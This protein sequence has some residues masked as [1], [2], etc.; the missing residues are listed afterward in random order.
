MAIDSLEKLVASFST[1]QQTFPVKYGAANYAVT[2]YW[3]SSWITPGSHVGG[4]PTA[5]AGQVCD[6]TTVGR[7]NVDDAGSGNTL[8]LSKMIFSPTL[9]VG[10]YLMDRLVAT[11][12]LSGTAMAAQSVNSVALP[13]RGGNGTGAELWLEWYVTTGSTARTATV[14]YTNS[15]GTSGRI[16]STT[17]PVS[18]RLTSCIRVPLMPGDRGVQSVQS[19]QLSGSTG[20]TGNFGITIAKRIATVDNIVANSMAGLGPIGLN[21]PSIPNDNCLFFIVN[22]SATTS[23]SYD[24]ELTFVEG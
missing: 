14:T 12:G 10:A 7:I 21:L 24:T 5:G 9:A 11:S 16:S 23:A 17:I 4:I 2:G 19:V 15:E 18:T 3:N 22:S 6:G 13:A 20:T 8:Y 1:K